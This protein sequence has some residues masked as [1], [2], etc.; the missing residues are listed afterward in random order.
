MPQYTTVTKLKAEL[1]SDSPPDYTEEEWNTKLLEIIQEQ[2]QAVDDEVGGCYSFSYNSNLQKFPDIDDDPA[3]PATIEKCA[4]YLA[5][6][7]AL[8]YYSAIY[9]AD[10]NALR[11]KR[12]NWAEQKLMKIANG[13]IKISLAG[14]V[15]FSYPSAETMNHRDTDSD[16]VVFS[17][18][19]MD[20]RL[21]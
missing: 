20:N 4:R 14:T 3:A 21:P 5:A 19:E 18:D 7:D 8:G 2:S 9:N 15:L 11:L 12:R 10:D 1:P 6:S 13:D 16:D 17:K